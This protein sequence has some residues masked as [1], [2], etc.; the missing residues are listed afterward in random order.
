[1]KKQHFI[2]ILCLFLVFRVINA[3]DKPA[4][5]FSQSGKVKESLS[6]Q[7]STLGREV[8]YSIYLPPDYESSVRSYPVVYLLHG[9]T[10]DETAWVQFGEVNMASDKAIA[11]RT[12]PPM[13]IVMPDAGVTWYV[14]DYLGKNRYEDMFFRELIPFIDKTYHTRPSK[15]F[16]GVAGL[17]MGGYGALIYSLHHPDMFAACVAFSAAVRTDE[18]MMAL[19]EKEY[20]GK[21]SFIY[22]PAGKPQDRLTEN[23]RKNSVLDLVKNMPES[24]KSMVRFYIDCGDDDILY[25]GNSTLHIMMRDLKVPHEFRIRNGEHNWTYWR[26]G[27]TD[28][29]KF[30]GESFH[31]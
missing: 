29:L 22:G 13:I 28:G 6:F 18:E 23:W 4:N 2:P 5:G 24:Q 10:D 14:N 15:E 7:S 1:M 27:L 12:I 3:Q 20:A 31:R 25:K 21:F 17:S 19:D 26:T 11:D 8:K 9:Y 30:I 16:R